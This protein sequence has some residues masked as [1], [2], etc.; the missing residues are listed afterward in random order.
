MMNDV[1]RRSPAHLAGLAALLL[2]LTAGGCAT[3]SDVRIIQQ[4]IMALQLR[5]DSLFRESQRQNRLL[6]D[7]IRSSFAAQQ[8]MRG[9]TSHRF[10]QLEQNL[11]RLEEMIN[12]TQLLMAQLTDRLSRPGLPTVVS[13][14]GDAMIAPAGEAEAMYQAAMQKV[15][16][17]SYTTARMAFEQIIELHPR[18]PRAPDAQ[19]QL[20]ETYYLEQDLDRAI[21]EFEKLER[22]WNTSPRAPEAL[23]RAGVIAQENNQTAKARQ[24]FQQV[25]QGYPASEAAREA[26]RRLRLLR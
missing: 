23:L 26:N 22:Q 8:D 20:A 9:E 25:N 24:L 19:F 4:D 10:L 1:T 11:G 5:Q 6:L 2:M 13:P 14:G 16:E 3:K 12:Q 18:D 17:G 7:T 15:S 21:E